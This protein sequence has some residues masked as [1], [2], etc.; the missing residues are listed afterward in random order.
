MSSIKTLAV[1]AV[2][3]LLI[4]GYEVSSQ[5]V[6]I[7]EDCGPDNHCTADVGLICGTDKKC[8]CGSGP[9]N[10]EVSF[11]LEWDTGKSV[12]VAIEGSACIGTE[13]NPVLEGQKSVECKEGACNQLAGMPPGVGVCAA[14][15]PSST[16]TETPSSSTTAGCSGIDG[17]G[18]LFTVIASCLLLMRN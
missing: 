8:A 17:L 5:E 9:L 7:G 11:E 1:V 13:A 3:A 10:H 2:I 6:G 16:T 4:C 12:C 14:Q 15:V 18:M